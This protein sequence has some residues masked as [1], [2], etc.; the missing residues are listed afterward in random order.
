MIDAADNTSWVVVRESTEPTSDREPSGRS[1]ENRDAGGGPLTTEVVLEFPGFGAEAGELH[2]VLSLVSPPLRGVARAPLQLVAVLDRSGSMSG[3]KLNFVSRTILFI[4]EHLSSRDSL[5]IVAFDSDMKVL[6]GLTMCTEEGR[7]RLRASVCSLRAGSATNLSGGLLRGL[8]LHAS[9]GPLTVD[10]NDV[11]A[12]VRSTFLFTDGIANCGIKESG[13]ICQAVGNKL[14]ELG[15][16]ACTI[17][18][19]GFGTDHCADLLKGVAQ[20]GGGVYCYIADEDSIGA[21]FGEA[22]GG[23]LSTTH[24]NARLDLEL[25]SEVGIART[26]TH[27]ATEVSTA[28]DGRQL[29]RVELGD[30]FAEERR[31]VLVLL[32]LPN[33]AREGPQSLGL[34]RAKGFSVVALRSEEA[35]PV[36]LMVERC[37]C[38]AAVEARHE[39]VERQFN[40]HIATEALDAAQRAARNRDLLAARAHLQEAEASIGASHAFSDGCAVSRGLHANMLEC[41]EGL[42]S[43]DAYDAQVSKTMATMSLAHTMQRSCGQ[44]FSECY[45]SEGTLKMKSMCM[46]AVNLSSSR[47]GAIAPQSQ[48]APCSG[49]RSIDDVNI[50]GHPNNGALTGVVRSCGTRVAI[51]KVQ[52]QTQQHKQEFLKVIAEFMDVSRHLVRFLAPRFSGSIMYVLTELM[53]RGSMTMLVKSLDGQGVPPRHLA[54]ISA[55]VAE[56][57]FFLQRVHHVHPSLWPSNVLANSLGEVKLTGLLEDD[58]SLETT[59]TATS[60]TKFLYMAPERCMGEDLSF[61]CNIWSMGVIVFELAAGRHPFASAMTSFPVLFEALCERPEP[62]LDGAEHPADLRDF[63]ASCLMR[64]VALRPDCAALKAHAFLAVDAGA[65]DEFALW[66]SLLS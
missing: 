54:Y 12:V 6:A 43:Q 22:L 49:E 57:L 15:S 30:L 9:K 31:D 19:F 2:A 11:Q 36:E 65:K 8:D 27:F 20:K 3:T 42:T 35:K 33:A 1:E 44:N 41:L 18:T 48:G 24:Q 62:Q 40:R 64:E 16:E 29:L 13:A 28:A 4:L 21:A 5:A 45:A 23:V 60:S 7:E 39:H 25:A 10:T 52:I 46:E 37:P 61:N 32:S 38:T 26:M 59:A 50:G 51:K 56:G 66:L 34:L 47:G 58:C 55:Q 63:T 14:A 53:D 17:S